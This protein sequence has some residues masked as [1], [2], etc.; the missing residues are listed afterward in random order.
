MGLPLEPLG[1]S[2]ENLVVRMKSALV[3]ASDRS[4]GRLN[5]GGEREIHAKG[6]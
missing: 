5:I 4:P 6:Y 1:A 2:L 3:G